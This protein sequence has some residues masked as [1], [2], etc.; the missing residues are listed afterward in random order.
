MEVF[1]KTSKRKR[2]AYFPEHIPGLFPLS[3]GDVID[4]LDFLQSSDLTNADNLPAKRMKQ[5]SDSDIESMA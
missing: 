3:R 5:R 1:L 2:K 4:D